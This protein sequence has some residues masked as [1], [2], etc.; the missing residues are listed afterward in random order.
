MALFGDGRDAVSGE[1]GLVVHR[2][3]RVNP[4]E[5]VDRREHE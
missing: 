1:L 2:G 3:E 4:D 5:R